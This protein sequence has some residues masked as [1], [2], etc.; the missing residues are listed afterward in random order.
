[1]KICNNPYNS[2]WTDIVA[3]E[4]TIDSGYQLLTV[5]WPAVNVRIAHLKIAHLRIACLRMARLRIA[6][7][8]IA[9]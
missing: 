6:R 2:S 7:L 9:P 1:M 8:R 4:S 3:G 5:S